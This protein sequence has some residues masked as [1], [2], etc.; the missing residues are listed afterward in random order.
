MT[1]KVFLVGAG[2]GDPELLTVKARN[3]LDECDII[4]Y[5]NLVD[6]S[7][8]D[9]TTTEK[10]YVGKKP[11]ESSKQKN[12]NEIMEEKAKEGLDVCR[13]KG[14]TPVIFGRGGEEY[15]YLRKRGIDVEYVPG[16][17][18]ST[19]V[20]PLNG[21]SLTD[22][23]L[24]SSLSILTGYGKG[25][26]EPEWKTVGDTAVVLMTLGNLE[27]V[28][29]R[30]KKHGEMDENTFSALISSGATDQEFM[31]VSELSRIV[32]FRDFFEIETPGMLVAGD[33]VRERLR[34]EGSDVAIFRPVG[35][36]EETE[37]I[38][39]RSG[40]IPRVH[41]ICKTSAIEENV[42]KV[43]KLN[44]EYMMFMSTE[45]VDIISDSQDLSDQKCI[46]IGEKTAERLRD[47]GVS[48]LTVPELQN[49]EGVENL[50]KEIG[51][52][53]KDFLALRSS[54]ADYE[55]DGAK[56]IDIYDVEVDEETVQKIFE[57][58]LKD[59]PGYTVVTSTGMFEL[60][61]DNIDEEKQ[62]EFVE[63]FNRS[64]IVS[65]GPKCSRNI[66]EKGVNVNYEMEKPDIENFFKEVVPN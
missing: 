12:I 37:K 54:L 45:G 30:L 5:D 59:P 63:N 66:M 40:G 20:P 26:S 64:F 33:V 62:E 58:Y 61:Y 44:P 29:E 53:K 10:M 24:S 56:N 3:L 52:N 42:R 16:I 1:G 48:Y 15:R 6:E 31:V 60:I 17:S 50:I 38:I 49:S 55:I 57:S 65:I 36:G 28:V 2:P 7:V 35:K 39:E 9:L 8:L 41:E 19:G 13:L 32:Y 23:E 27:N 46:A 18:S 4:L 34:V 14:G 11:G 51:G 47:K 25:G 22:R 43:G 21:I